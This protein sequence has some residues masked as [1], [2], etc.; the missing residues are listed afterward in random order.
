MADGREVIS[1]LRRRVGGGSGFVVSW[2]IG[3]DVGTVGVVGD[4]ATFVTLLLTLV[5]FGCLK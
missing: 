1:F 5:D 3:V 4:V 2:T